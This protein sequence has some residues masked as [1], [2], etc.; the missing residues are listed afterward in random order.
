MMFEMTGSGTNVGG[1]IAYW[2]VMSHGVHE[3][4]IFP[5]HFE[6]TK[7]GWFAYEILLPPAVDYGAQVKT[8]LQSIMWGK[9]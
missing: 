4:I 1:Y 6:R 9:P 3:G 5:N 2:A 8:M 7:Y